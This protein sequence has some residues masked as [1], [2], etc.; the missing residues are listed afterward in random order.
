MTLF[1]NVSIFDLESILKQ[2]ILPI[3]RTGNDWENNN[4]ADNSKEVVYLF[5]PLTERNTFLQYGSVLLEVDVETAVLNEML[6]TDV[7]IGLYD[8]Y[9]IP[10]VK[11][12]EI[13]KVY[14]PRIYSKR[15]EY[16]VEKQTFKKITFV[17]ISGEWIQSNPAESRFAT[18]KGKID[19]CLKKRIENANEII[20]D[21]LNFF[22]TIQYIDPVMQTQRKG[23]YRC[24]LATV[25]Y[26][27]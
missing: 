23:S 26:K 1:K 6:P 13:T 7:N 10:E 24:E 17:E 20:I 9:I 14:F 15:I 8:E 16:M 19:N 12:E 4:R 3:S 22:E 21:N 5:N 25:R 27:I 2:G 18:I 11:P